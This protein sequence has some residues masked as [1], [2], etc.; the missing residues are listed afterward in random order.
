[1]KLNKTIF[2]F[3][4]GTGL[5]LGTVS[6]SDYLD[7]EPITDRAVE[8]SDTPYTK[9]SEAEDLMNTIYNDLGNEYW[10][11]DYFFNG[12]AQTDIA[13]QGGDNP[14]NQQQA[15][16]R[17]LATN[18]N[19]SRDW[20][21]IYG[22]INNCNKVLNYVDNITDPALTT[23]R[24]NEMKAEAA[25]MRAL[26]Y[27]HAVQ[28]WGDVPLVT[29]AVIGVTAEN[30]DEV[31][32][33][34]YPERKPAEEVY[35]LILS[36]LESALPNAPAS[37]NKYRATRGA[38]LSLLAQVNATK[39]SPDFNKVLTYTTQLIGEGYSLL[40]NFDN[41]FDGNHDAN[42]ESIFEINGNGSSIWWWGTSMFIGNDWKKFNTPSNDLVAS[43]DS[44]N[45]IV[46]KESTV[47]FESV[48]WADNYW[49]SSNYPFA[50]KQRDTSGNQNVYIFRYADLL[51]L[52]AEAMVRTG[53]YGG[54][55][56]IIDQIRSR[57]G[58]GEISTITNENDGINK[59]LWERK[60]EL[61]FEG[62][63]WFDLKRTGKALEILKNRKDG[64]GNILSFV[65]NLTEQK[66]IWPIPQTQIDNNPNLTQNPGY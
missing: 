1:M 45:D 36:D 41:L 19:V 46:R 59:I 30:F 22:R 10:Q 31:Y 44:E 7:T 9:A 27:F 56:S 66:L 47:K 50:W 39:P 55:K 12:D 57:V 5:M 37:S 11:L 29:K 63:R 51:L 25:T 62:Q 40:T 3:I 8:F 34:V 64:N 17:I 38:A 35:G 49:P 60:L 28:L 23:E 6:C 18:S 58:L 48:G 26:Y 24:K 14:Q 33:Q 4:L 32:S 2:Y 21:Y 42:S 65:S 20:G 43:Y 13:Y 15:E 52:R 54:A 61:A 16:Y 53:D